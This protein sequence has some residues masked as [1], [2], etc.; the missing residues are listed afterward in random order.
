M[1]KEG[2]YL[3]KDTPAAAEKS[4]RT[5]NPAKNATLEGSLPEKVS[6]VAQRAPRATGKGIVGAPYQPN[7]KTVGGPYSNIKP[8]PNFTMQGEPYTKSYSKEL[9]AS[10]PKPTSGQAWAAESASVSPGQVG[11][12]LKSVGGKVL[13]ALNKGGTIWDAATQYSQ[14][15]NIEE[16][17][18]IKAAK[19]DPDAQ[20]VVA[21]GGVNPILEAT[22]KPIRDVNA[23]VMDKVM[24]IF[25]G[26]PDKK[27]AEK[28][29]TAETGK[30]LTTSATFIPGGAVDQAAPVQKAQ[31]TQFETTRVPEAATAQPGT[32]QY[33]AA[34]IDEFAQPKGSA[35][36]LQQGVS[37][38]DGGN[39]R[40]V[41]GPNGQ[42]VKQNTDSGE[43]VPMSV[44]GITGNISTPGEESPLAREARTRR[45]TA[46]RDALM[47]QA[48]QPIDANTNVADVGTIKRN[49]LAAQQLLEQMDKSQQ[50]GAQLGMEEKKLA[51]SERSTAATQEQN[52]LAKEADQRIRDRQAAATEKQADIAAQA[53]ERK[54][55]EKTY[56]VD[57]KAVKMTDARYKQYQTEKAR[58]QFFKTKTKK[59][60]L[61]PEEAEA[62]YAT[63]VAAQ[64]QVAKALADPKNAD[65]RDAIKA[66]YRKAT[67]LDYIE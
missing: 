61:S 29:P 22:K 12:A 48:F 45:E 11:S 59:E 27:V 21:Q 16:V 51:S 52:R 67:G 28:Q 53:E 66:A 8:D 50:A 35:A 58:D 1:A 54:A 19:G 41:Q 55:S 10:K 43:V 17:M 38:G 37:R 2:E 26:S 25:A 30:P 15:A 64:S 4:T 18:R 63:V 31:P 6:V 47:R 62:E 34:Q 42:V 32:P 36:G 57:G 9:V 40:Y 33:T 65:K 44:Q 60:G 14:P 39:F 13:S 56:L 46:F 3:P 49:R 7:F 5:F 20:R 23:A 24:G